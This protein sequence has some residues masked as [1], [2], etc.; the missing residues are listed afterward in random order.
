MRWNEQ[1]GS[2]CT[3]W[4]IIANIGSEL[5]EEGHGERTRS[6][7]IVK[8]GGEQTWGWGWG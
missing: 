8:F 4:A 6:G 5:V 7:A 2:H 1:L 3:G